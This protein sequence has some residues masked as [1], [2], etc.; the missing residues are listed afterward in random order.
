MEGGVTSVI[1]STHKRDS[2]S[3]YEQ[4]HLVVSSDLDTLELPSQHL[5]QAVEC[6]G[7]VM[8]NSLVVIL[9]EKH[10]PYGIMIGFIPQ[11]GG[12]IENAVFR[13][14]AFQIS[15]GCL[16]IVHRARQAMQK[17]KQ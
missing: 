6:V 15:D 16:F 1:S 3:S 7:T 12:A 11:N 9:L 4:G 10:S 2:V 14:I 5:L 13:Q 17:I 8:E